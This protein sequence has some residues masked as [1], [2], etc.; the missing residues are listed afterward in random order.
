[1]RKPKRDQKKQKQ[2]SKQ[3]KKRRKFIIVKQRHCSVYCPLTSALL[4]V[5][6]YLTTAAISKMFTINMIGHAKKAL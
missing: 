3:W 6:W 5:L 2:Q 4:Y 1:M